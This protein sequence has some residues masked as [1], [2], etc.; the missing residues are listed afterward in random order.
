MFLR[1]YINISI[2]LISLESFVP[3]VNNRFVEES[4]CVC[5]LPYKI[6]AKPL[7]SP[8]PVRQ[9]AER[10]RRHRVIDKMRKAKPP[11]CDDPRGGVDC[12][13]RQ[14]K[15]SQTENPGE[16]DV[17]GDEGVPAKGIGGTSGAGVG[18]GSWNVPGQEGQQPCE[19]AEGM[20]GLQLESEPA[21]KEVGSTPSVVR[22]VE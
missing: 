9:G 1:E 12:D 11:V 3:E 2:P 21:C 22:C 20:S 14:K 8:G 7:Q 19:L 4:T 18:K 13:V 6:R 10:G 16:I 17:E 5:F 15:E